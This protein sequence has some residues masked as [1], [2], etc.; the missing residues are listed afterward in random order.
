MRRLA[1][2]V[3]GSSPVAEWAGPIDGL[4]MRSKELSIDALRYFAYSAA[5]NLAFETMED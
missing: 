3:S 1:L 5:V 2:G 4:A